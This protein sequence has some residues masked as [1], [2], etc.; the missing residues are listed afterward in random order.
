MERELRVGAMK[1]G[2]IN[3]RY[4]HILV[5]CLAQKGIDI[6]KIAKLLGHKDIRKV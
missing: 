5:E 1:H 3:T 2:G 4:I 6:Y